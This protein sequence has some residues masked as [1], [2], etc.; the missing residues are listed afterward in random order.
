MRGYFKTVSMNIRDEFRKCCRF[1]PVDHTVDASASGSLKKWVLTR[2]P[3]EKKTT[4][5][6]TLPQPARNDVPSKILSGLARA[7]MHDYFFKDTMATAAV[8]AS[9]AVVVVVVVVLV[10]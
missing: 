8:V 10:V 1:V 9:G 6:C 7:V 5:E 4:E 3:W 2:C